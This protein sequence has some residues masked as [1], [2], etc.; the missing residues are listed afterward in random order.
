MRLDTPTP[1]AVEATGLP[2][3]AK[4]A[5]AAARGRTF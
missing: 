2:V 5:A 3:A 1:K 4:C